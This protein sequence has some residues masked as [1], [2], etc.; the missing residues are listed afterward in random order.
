[1]EKLTNKNMKRYLIRESVTFH[2]ITFKMKMLT[3]GTYSFE[4][5]GKSAFFFFHYGSPGWIFRA[6]TVYSIMTC[7]MSSLSSFRMVSIPWAAAVFSIA[8]VA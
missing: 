8:V 2:S 1:M 4:R 6:L 7:V 3:F 5:P